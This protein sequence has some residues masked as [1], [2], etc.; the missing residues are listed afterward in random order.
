MVEYF[1]T[2]VRIIS[3]NSNTIS[4]NYI[5]SYLLGLKCL[6]KGTLKLTLHPY[7]KL[8][9]EGPIVKPPIRWISSFARNETFRIE[10]TVTDKKVPYMPGKEMRAKSV[11]VEKHGLFFDNNAT[12]S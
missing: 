9:Q 1:I 11:P 7:N 2:Q 12:H 3:Y 4:I 5:A 10:C 8:V 6:S